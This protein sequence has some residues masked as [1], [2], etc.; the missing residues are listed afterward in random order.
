M[1]QLNL[2]SYIYIYEQILT[3]LS[4]FKNQIKHTKKN[5]E[6]EYHQNAN[7]QFISKCIYVILVWQTRHVS[8]KQISQ[9]ILITHCICHQTASLFLTQLIDQL[10]ISN[11]TRFDQHHRG[12]DVSRKKRG[13]DKRVILQI[14]QMVSIVVGLM[15]L[16]DFYS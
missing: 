4:N 15:L 3:N 16:F 2:C 9:Q 14:V 11:Q 7:K 13:W 6:T 5:F 12:K 8:H 1:R 10:V